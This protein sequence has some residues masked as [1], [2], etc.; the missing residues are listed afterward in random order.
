IFTHTQN[1][2]VLLYLKSFS[3]LLFRCA[4]NKD[5]I[6]FC[7]KIVD[8]YCKLLNL[9]NKIRGQHK[10]ILSIL[11]SVL[12]FQTEGTGKNRLANGNLSSQTN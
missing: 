8:N 12:P 5:I 9:L 4:I 3:P 2:W 1:E 10:T 7:K 6:G 11:A